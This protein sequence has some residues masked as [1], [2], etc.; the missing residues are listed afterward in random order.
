MI[1]RTEGTDED[2]SEL[3]R[4]HRDGFEI[5]VKLILRLDVEESDENMIQREIEK[6][7][8]LRHPC[9]ATPFGFVLSS[10]WRELKIVRVY[11]GFDSLEKVLQTSPSWW[12]ATAKS[13]AIV[14]IVL[15]LQ[16]VQSFGIIHGDVQPSNILFDES[17][18]I[19]I[20]DIFRYRSDSHKQESRQGSRWSAPEVVS[21]E[22]LTRKSDVFSFALILLAIVVGHHDFQKPEGDEDGC[23]FSGDVIPWFVPAFVT[24]LIKSGLSID[25]SARPSFDTII[26]ELKTNSF[27]IADDVN[28]DEVSSFVNSVELSE[29]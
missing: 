7:M 2:Q 6:M 8:N 28:S 19:Q 17:H 12:T 20:V 11:D 27:R 13:I 5:I 14:G 24:R 15:G 25:P 22:S 10:N 9:V 26:E 1:F 4:R 16:F 3:Y 23:V 29:S 18:R 21:G